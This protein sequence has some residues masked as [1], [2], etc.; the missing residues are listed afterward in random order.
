MGFAQQINT[1]VNAKF[2]DAK[3]QFDQISLNIRQLLALRT[4]IFDVNL[5][6]LLEQCSSKLAPKPE[7]FINFYLFGHICGSILIPERGTFVKF[8][9]FVGGG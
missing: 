4:S 2:E 7:T 6:A 8:W 9:R 1:Q 3:T 5:K